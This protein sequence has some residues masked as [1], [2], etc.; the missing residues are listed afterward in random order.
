MAITSASPAPGGTEPLLMARWSMRWTLP[1]TIFWFAVAAELI[2]LLSTGGSTKGASPHLPLG[3]A[4]F[5]A[6]FAIVASLAATKGVCRL[7]DRRIQLQVD[8]SGVYCRFLDPSF[9]ASS[10]IHRG[11][12]LAGMYQTTFVLAVS[13][14]V[15]STRGANAWNERLRPR[16]K[17]GVMMIG[18]LAIA[19][20]DCRASEILKAVE[21]TTRGLAPADNN[22]PDT[23]AG[24]GKPAKRDGN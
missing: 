19:M 15:H 13:A 21:E 8:R 18:G 3:V 16:R 14:D 23:P 24:T 9:V 17:E 2:S 11:A 4:L 10:Q 5:L 12:I 7:F 1:L 22:C 6:P 20:L